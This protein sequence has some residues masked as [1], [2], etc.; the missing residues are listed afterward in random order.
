MP[1]QFKDKNGGLI[2]GHSEK[3]KD[4]KRPETSFQAGQGSR[5]SRNQGYGAQGKANTVA[6]DAVDTSTMS[7]PEKLKYF[8]ELGLIGKEEEPKPFN[9]KTLLQDLQSTLEGRPDLT[10]QIVKELQGL[11]KGAIR[12]VAEVAYNS[13]QRIKTKTNDPARI[14]QYLVREIQKAK[15]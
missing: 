2:A 11:D 10:Q 9:P 3:W 4:S 13:L 14:T 8:R 6:S 7:A 5:A 15:E 1:N 12:H